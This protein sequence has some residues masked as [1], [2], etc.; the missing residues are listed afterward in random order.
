MSHVNLTE[1]FYLDHILFFF[2]G[3][4]RETE[5]EIFRFFPGRKKNLAKSN[6]LS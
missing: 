3:L 5:K 2:W 6:F 1:E 4:R